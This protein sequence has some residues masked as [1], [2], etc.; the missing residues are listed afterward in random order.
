MKTDIILDRN[1]SI[2]V[3]LFREVEGEARLLLVEDCMGMRTR[4]QL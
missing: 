3:D 2:I 4:Q 1:A